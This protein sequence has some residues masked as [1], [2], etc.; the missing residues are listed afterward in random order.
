MKS[1]KK[2]PGQRNPEPE[3]LAELKERLGA[4]IRELRK[5]NGFDNYEH[6]AYEHEISR[7]QYGRFEKGENLTFVTLVRLTN[8][9]GISLKDFF[10]EGF[11]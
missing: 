4:R 2:K 6:F 9:F 11:D 1:K 10:S 8:A 5:Q 3:N 7:S